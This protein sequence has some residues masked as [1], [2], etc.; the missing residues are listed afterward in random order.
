M[1]MPGLPELRRALHPLDAPP[2]GPGWNLPE[3]DGL[4]PAGAMRAEAAVL[5]GL[6]P[7]ASGLQVLLTRRTEMLRQHAGQVSFPGGRVEPGDAGPLAAALREAGEEI[8]LP[9]AQAEP[10]GWLDPLATITGYRVLPVVARISPAFEPVPDPGE[11]AEVFEVPLAFLM[12]P[13]NLARIDI[14]FAGRMRQV[15]EFRQHGDAGDLAADARRIWGA[16]A[17]ILANFRDRLE[18]V[19]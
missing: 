16:T 9:P 8:G 6:L 4:L 2:A 12:A 15:L 5:V 19:R 11:V 18:A 10:L 17:S 7:R 1:P 14:E 13:A 3:L